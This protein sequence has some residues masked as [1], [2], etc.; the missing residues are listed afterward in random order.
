M[1]RDFWVFVY[2][3][4]GEVYMKTIE[5]LQSLKT[6][7]NTEY[8]KLKKELDYWELQNRQMKL[9]DQHSQIHLS[10]SG[11]HISSS[12]ALTEYTTS[13]KYRKK[14]KYGRVLQLFDFIILDEIKQVNRKIKALE[15]AFKK[16]AR[17][18]LGD[19]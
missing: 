15:S 9:P 16:E 6:K 5:A 18:I 2:N 10:F 1:S 17:K 3:Y 19:N 13:Y 4:G 14:A 8:E 7:F 12:I 11:G